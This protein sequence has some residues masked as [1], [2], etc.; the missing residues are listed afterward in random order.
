MQQR[1]QVLEQQQR[2]QQVLEQQRQQQ[3]L[4][5][6]LQEQG[7][8]QELVLLQ[9]VR[10]Q[11]QRLLLFCH[12]QTGKRPTERQ[13]VRSISLYFLR[14]FSVVQV[15]VIPEKSGAPTDRD[16]LHVFCGDL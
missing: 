16:I 3:V 4:E 9:Q 14:K 8:Q 1:Q 12:K 13:A 15:S 2:Q 6:Q 5:Q 7:Q 11:E 10:E